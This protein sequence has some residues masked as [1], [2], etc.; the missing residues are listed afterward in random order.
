MQECYSQRSREKD[1]GW[2]KQSSG[3]G[4]GNPLYY[5]CLENPTHRGAW[6][7]TVHRV[8]QS[9]TRLKRLSSSNKQSLE[10][11]EERGRGCKSRN[12]GGLWKLEETRKQVLPWK[13][14]NATCWPT[15]DFWLLELKYNNSVLFQTTK[16]VVNFYSCSSKLIHLLF[17]LYIYATYYLT[18]IC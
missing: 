10:W 1:I 16:F 17:P 6:W 15:L 3:E 12:A 7:A 9:R 2:W 13:P 5:S 11:C 14:Q 4:N 8:A 18:Y